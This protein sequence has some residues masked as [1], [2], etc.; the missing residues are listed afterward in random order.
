MDYDITKNVRNPPEETSTTIPLS[1]E[2][3]RSMDWEERGKGE[4]QGGRI[5]GE[6]RTSI[7]KNQSLTLAAP[8]YST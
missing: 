8:A 2:E 5:S 3:V 4:R 6:H 7:S 1:N